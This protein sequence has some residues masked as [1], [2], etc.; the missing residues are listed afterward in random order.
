MNIPLLSLLIWTPIIGG[1]WVLL[2][3]GQNNSETSRAVALTV[4]LVTFVLS[5]PLYIWYEL[6]SA[7]MQFTE[8]TSWIPAFGISYQLG[9]DGFSM[10]LILLTTF[11]TVLVIIAG[12]VVIKD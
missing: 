6:G 9:I 12:W 7:Q 11:T 2:A 10:P 1:V 8:H 4:A 5:L 3:G